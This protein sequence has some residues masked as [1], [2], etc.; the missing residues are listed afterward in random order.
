LTYEGYIAYTN[1]M[2][3]DIN[4]ITAAEAARIKSITLRAMLDAIQDGRVRGGKFK[5][6]ILVE[7]ETLADF[8]P[9]P[10]KRR[11]EEEVRG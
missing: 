7:Q 1:G 3:Y 2:E 4:Y 11:D 10:N 6:R 8:Q 5:G 9:R